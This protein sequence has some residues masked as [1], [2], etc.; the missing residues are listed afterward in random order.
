MSNRE[1][2]ARQ[3]LQEKIALSDNPYYLE[4]SEDGEIELWSFT[5]DLSS[6]ETFFT[7]ET[8]D[9]VEAAYARIFPPPGSVQVRFGYR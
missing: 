4:E 7:G 1:P 6:V 8:F 9:S 5:D 3:D 2:K